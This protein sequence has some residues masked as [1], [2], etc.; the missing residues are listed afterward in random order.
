MRQRGVLGHA[1]DRKESGTH[2]EVGQETKSAALRSG[3]HRVGIHELQSQSTIVASRSWIPSRYVRARRLAQ[4]RTTGEAGES[5]ARASEGQSEPGVLSKRNEVRSTCRPAPRMPSGKLCGT[6]PRRSHRRDQGRFQL[7]DR[8][9]RAG[10]ARTRAC[11]SGQTRARRESEERRDRVGPGPRPR[12]GHAHQGAP[13]QASQR[14]PVHSLTCPP[15]HAEPQG[16]FKHALLLRRV[17]SARRL[18]PPLGPRALHCLQ[19]RAS[20]A[21]LRTT[22]A[23]QIQ[24]FKSYRDETAVDPFSSVLLSR[25]LTPRSLAGPGPEADPR[26]LHLQTRP[27]PP[28]RPQRLGQ[29]QLLLGDPVRPVG[30]LHVALARGAPVAPARR[31]RR[32]GRRDHERICRDRVRQLGRPLPDQCVQLPP[33]VAS[34]APNRS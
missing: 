23:L 15:C 22:L 30:C 28:R 20:Q 31:R 9:Q 29:V 13:R 4:S 3:A 21:D 7:V 32:D 19:G 25:L 11:A 16:E 27:Q 18:A 1:R 14:A 10:S 12:H 26:R 24:G 8:V 33:L 34:L 5:F 2:E 17:S 6:A